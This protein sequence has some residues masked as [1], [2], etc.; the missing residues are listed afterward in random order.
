MPVMQLRKKNSSRLALLTTF[1][2]MKQNAA[3]MIWDIQII[4]PMVLRPAGLASHRP[5]IRMILSTSGL[6]SLPE[7][8]APT[9]VTIITMAGITLT[10]AALSREDAIAGAIYGKCFFQRQPSFSSDFYSS[11]MRFIYC[12]SDFLS[13][14]A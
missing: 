3:T 8:R 10:P 9:A 12:P 4:M 2:V 5:S 6:I 7:V 1:L 11:A 14:L 13:G